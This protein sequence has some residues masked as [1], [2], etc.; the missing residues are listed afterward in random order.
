MTRHA[1]RLLMVSACLA[2]ELGCHDKQAPEP[3]AVETPPAP[4][5]LEAGERLPEAETAF[6]LPIPKGMRLTRHFNDAAYFA[7]DLDMQ[8]AIA[9]VQSHVSSADV[10]IVSRR[11]VFGRASIHGDQTRRL[12]RIEVSRTPGGSQVH[13]KNITPAPAVSGL[14]DAEIWKLAGRKPDGTPLDENQIY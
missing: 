9:H 2:A 13:I 5:R 3:S 6:G 12:F 8:S 1:A 11:A 4:D 14:S 10:E 7:G